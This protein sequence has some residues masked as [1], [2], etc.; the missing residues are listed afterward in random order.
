MREPTPPIVI[1]VIELMASMCSAY[2]T[3]ACDGLKIIVSKH[4]YDQIYFDFS[5]AKSLHEGFDSLLSSSDAE[6]HLL[7]QFGVARIDNR[8]ES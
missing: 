4:T 1:E 7:T 6:I 3:D 2:G 8:E 5:K